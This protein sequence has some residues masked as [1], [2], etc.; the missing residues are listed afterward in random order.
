M[1]IIGILGGMGPESSADLYL[2]L[3]HKSHTFF[4][5]D[6]DK[7]PHILINNIPIP[8]IFQH[9]SN[10]V[11]IYLGKQIQI[12][13]NA[14]AEILGVC[15]N[16]AHYH[17]STIHNTLSGSV[18]LI[19]MIDKTVIQVKKSGYQC[20]GLLGTY[21]SQPLYLQT[22]Q[23]QKL[24]VLVPS[25]SFQYDVESIISQ[26]LSGNNGYIL[27]KQLIHIANHLLALGAECIVLGCTE[28]PLILNETEVDFPLYSSTK[29]LGDALFNCAI[30][31]SDKV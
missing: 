25:F 8:N 17:W 5:D 22:C 20:M 21:I 27:K 14:G 10:S 24:E 18:I 1:K 12:L 23:N 29:I 31:I 7:Y 28:L 30:N 6:F 9:N 16:S 19:N 2:Q 3:I 4:E 13:T 15:C 26:I 11:G